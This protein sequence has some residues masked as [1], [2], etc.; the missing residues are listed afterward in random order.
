MNGMKKIEVARFEFISSIAPMEPKKTSRW[1]Q[2]D[3]VRHFSILNGLPIVN[4]QGQTRMLALSYS[5]KTDIVIKLMDL[6]TLEYTNEFPLSYDQMTSIRNS[7]FSTY[8]RGS[9]F[10]FVVGGRVIFRKFCHN[11]PYYL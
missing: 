11:I 10:S 7:K 4:F 5:G 6:D 8:I 9:L 2:I 3:Y 1:K